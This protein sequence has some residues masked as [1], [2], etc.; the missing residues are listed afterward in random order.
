MEASIW[1]LVISAVSISFIHTASGPDHYLPF[2]VLSK[3]KQWSK[4]KT[5]FLT[6]VCGCSATDEKSTKKA[7]VQAVKWK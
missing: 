4:A 1:A 3:S 7:E 5:V 6:I 2:I